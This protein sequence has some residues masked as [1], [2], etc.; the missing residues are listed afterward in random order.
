MKILF[1]A[2]PFGDKDSEKKFHQAL[3]SIPAFKDVDEMGT[4]FLLKLDNSLTL[5]TI[6]ALF[7][8][9]DHWNIDNSPLESLNQLI[10]L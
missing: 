8:L 5:E 4:H 10:D 1:K 9:F 2:P 6:R 3:S 7:E